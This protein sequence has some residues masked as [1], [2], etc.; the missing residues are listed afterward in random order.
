MWP[1]SGFLPRARSGHFNHPSDLCF[2]T[3]GADRNGRYSGVCPEDQ[4]R[5][6]Q[7]CQGRVRGRQDGPHKRERSAASHR[8]HDREEQRLA[9]GAD[10][11]RQLLRV[12][13]QRRTHPPVA[14]RLP[15]RREDVAVIPRHAIRRIWANA[16]IRRS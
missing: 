1:E 16:R 7:D 14:R 5:E 6:L 12:D 4:D 3:K 10:R 2:L 13:A 8:C 11:L 15:E 9:T